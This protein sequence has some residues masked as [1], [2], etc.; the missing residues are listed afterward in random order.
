[1]QKHLIFITYF[2]SLNLAGCVYRIDIQQGNVVTQQ[3]V[4]QLRP[5]MTPNQVRYI[6]GT[7]LPKNPFQPKRWDYLYSF[8]QA[9]GSLKVQHLTLMFDDYDRLVGLRGDFRPHPE[10]SF[11]TPAVTPI[12]VPPRKIEQGIFEILGN[13]LRNLFS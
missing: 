4:N 5:G 11:Q 9:G 12:E 2:A 1:M 7:P 8:Q 10:S 6:I 3:Q 13:L